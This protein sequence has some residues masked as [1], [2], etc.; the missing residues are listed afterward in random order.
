MKLVILKTNIETKQRALILKSLFYNY[1]QITN[2]SVDT[3]DIDKVLRI[4]APG[5]IDQDEIIQL[6]KTCG[7]QCEELRD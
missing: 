5:N 7:F 6:V 1:A 3:E 4:E 2:W